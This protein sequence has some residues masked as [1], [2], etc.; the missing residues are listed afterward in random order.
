[1]KKFKTFTNFEEEE[2][3]LND[4]AVSGMILRN[5]QFLVFIILKRERQSF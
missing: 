4:M 2:K 3:F 5:V 1:M